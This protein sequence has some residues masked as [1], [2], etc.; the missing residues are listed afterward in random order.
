MNMDHCRFYNTLMDLRDCQEHM[1]DADLSEEEQD[2]RAELLDVC[3][4]IAKDYADKAT[5]P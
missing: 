2:A 5:N 4:R 3:W 1:D